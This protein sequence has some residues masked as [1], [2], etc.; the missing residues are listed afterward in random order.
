M[1]AGSRGLPHIVVSARFTAVSNFFLPHPEPPEVLRLWRL[2]LYTAV[3][4]IMTIEA[5]SGRA[6]ATAQNVFERIRRLVLFTDSCGSTAASLRKREGR[7]RPGSTS[8][9]QSM[10]TPGCR[11]IA[12]AVE[13]APLAQATG[14]KFSLLGM[15]VTINQCHP[16]CTGDR[17]GYRQGSHTPSLS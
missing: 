10:W 4:D 1:T 12:A 6:T 11:R 13:G 9:C 8:S 14:S 17:L 15:G 7:G 2:C 16:S 5:N 3:H